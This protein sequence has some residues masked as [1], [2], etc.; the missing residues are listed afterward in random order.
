MSDAVCE[1]R[2]IPDRLHR[3]GRGTVAVPSGERVYR[4]FKPDVQIG[5]S[6]NPNA[7]TF[8]D[9]HDVSVTLRSLCAY[10]TDVLYDHLGGDHRHDHAVGTADVARIAA[11]TVE[12][13]G[14]GMSTFYVEHDPCRCMYPHGQIVLTNSGER[15]NIKPTAKT[16]KRALRGALAQLFKIT[17]PPD[18]TFQ[19]NGQ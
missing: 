18:P 19:L 1:A 13:E 2:G 16:Y 5:A 17:H 8:Q 10:D 4:W 6:G 3:D 7:E 9:V 15:V 14:K 11:A 12:V